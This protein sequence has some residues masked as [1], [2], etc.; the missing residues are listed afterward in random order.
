M[1]A[2]PMRVTLHTG[3]RICDSQGKNLIIAEFEGVQIPDELLKQI[4]GG[5]SWDTEILRFLGNSVALVEFGR[6]VAE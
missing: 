1:R 3:L 5:G 6:R 2:T 4:A